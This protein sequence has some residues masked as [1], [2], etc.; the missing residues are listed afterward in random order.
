MADAMLRGERGRRGF[1]L[2]VAA[3]AMWGVFPLYWPL[4]EPAGAVEILAH[5]M[6]W[7]LL[8]DGS[9]RGRCSGRAAQVRALVA[10]R[11]ARALLASPRW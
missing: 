9:A 2:G 1:L 6:L 7:S 5:R 11:R 8:D 4:L 3:Y 10:D